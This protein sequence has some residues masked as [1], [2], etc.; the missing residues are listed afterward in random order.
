MRV[1]IWS[2]LGNFYNENN[3]LSNLPI[4]RSPFSINLLDISLELGKAKY[5]AISI[6]V[7]I[8]N[9]VISLLENQ[10]WPNFLHRYFTHLIIESY[11]KKSYISC[12]LFQLCIIVANWLRKTRISL[13]FK[14]SCKIQI[15][16]SNEAHH[17]RWSEFSICRNNSKHYQLSIIYKSDSNNRFPYSMSTAIF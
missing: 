3:F 13:Y 14:V 11:P 5:F 17:L 7:N 15:V 16:K 6:L 2:F 1:P 12:N 8:E 4:L 10:K 9:F